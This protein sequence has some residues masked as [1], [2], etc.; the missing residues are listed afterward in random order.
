MKVITILFALIALSTATSLKCNFARNAI[1]GYICE[2]RNVE[3]L[4]GEVV[5]IEHTDHMQ[6]RTD[7]DVK[8]VFYSLK[9]FYLLKLLF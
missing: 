6:D 1:F 9:R 4:E 8:M 2:F 5:T 3:V 7:A